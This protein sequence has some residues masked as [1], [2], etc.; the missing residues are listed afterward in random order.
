M[1]TMEAAKRRGRGRNSSRDVESEGERPMAKQGGRG[2]IEKRGQGGDEQT[3][4]GQS[5]KEKANDGRLV[6]PNKLKL[7][8]G[9]K[10]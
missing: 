4:R 8:P 5:H 9:S 7:L 10:S 6:Q 2:K 1:K 3:R